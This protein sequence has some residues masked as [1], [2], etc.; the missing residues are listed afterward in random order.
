MDLYT[1]EGTMNLPQ[2]G[3]EDITTVSLTYN[4]DRTV[5]IASVYMAIEDQ[6]PPPLLEKLVQ[7]CTNNH[8]PL[9]LACDINAQDPAWGV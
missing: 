8:T 3:N 9:V 1:N 4:Q 7:H 2:F 5:I 6:V